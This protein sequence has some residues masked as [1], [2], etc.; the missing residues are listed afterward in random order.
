LELEPVVVTVSFG[1]EENLEVVVGDEGKCVDSGVE[2]STSTHVAVRDNC[3]CCFS[4][5]LRV[6]EIVY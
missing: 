2:E 1:T 5:F 6:L 4:Q 3:T